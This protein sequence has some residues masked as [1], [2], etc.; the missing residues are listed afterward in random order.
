MH[1][2]VSV[3]QRLELIY[4]ATCLTS[5]HPIMSFNG[6]EGAVIEL[7]AAAAL[8]AE[9]RKLNP[10]ETLGHFLGRDLLSSILNQ[11]GC[12]GIRVYYG[13]DSNGAKQ[14]IFVGADSNEDDMTSG[15]IA[16]FCSPCPNRCSSANSLNGL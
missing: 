1:S 5:K 2:E 11:S 4:L 3:Y 15:I 14:L 7:D 12:M 13:V 6:S 16:D 10:G 9:Y 8:T